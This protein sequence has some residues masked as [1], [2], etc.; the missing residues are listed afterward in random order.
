[1]KT[2]EDKRMVKLEFLFFSKTALFGPILK[3][4]SHSLFGAWSF[5]LVHIQIT[6]SEAPRGF[7]IFFNFFSKKLDHGSWTIKPDRG[8]RPSSMVQLQGPWW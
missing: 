7:V 2:K 6:P 5:L 4:S 8:K 3:Q 1:M